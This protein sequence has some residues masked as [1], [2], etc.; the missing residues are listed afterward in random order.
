LGKEWPR[1]ILNLWRDLLLG[2]RDS[3][4]IL[5][6]ANK[7]SD[8]TLSDGTFVS[9]IFGAACEIADW[10]GPMAIDCAPALARCLSSDKSKVRAFGAA[11]VAGLG[12]KINNGVS[13]LDLLPPTGDEFDRLFSPLIHASHAPSALRTSAEIRKALMDKSTAVVRAGLLAA[14]RIGP[15]GA[16]LR[17]ELTICAFSEDEETS[18]YA[19]KI[20]ARYGVQFG[21]QSTGNDDFFT[22]RMAG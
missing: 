3:D 2:A 16:Q 14:E 22:L 20:L 8:T 4:F 9:E 18:K 1:A 13:L 10:T 6:A 21:E 7:A 19:R 12:T 15:N 17:G 5:A 11:I